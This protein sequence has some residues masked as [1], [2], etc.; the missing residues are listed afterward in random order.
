MIL[1]AA[2]EAATTSQMEWR[3]NDSVIIPCCL[4]G[5]KAQRAGIQALVVGPGEHSPII[6][7]PYKLSAPRICFYHRCPACWQVFPHHPHRA[8]SSNSSGVCCRH[9]CGAHR[10]R[11]AI[12]RRTCSTA[13]VSIRRFAQSATRPCGELRPNIE[14]RAQREQERGYPIPATATHNGGMRRTTRNWH[15]YSL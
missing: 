13:P 7:Y 10:E 4:V 14:T 9:A 12:R 3:L 5:R 11:P 1:I 8:P 2:R 6:Y 15:R